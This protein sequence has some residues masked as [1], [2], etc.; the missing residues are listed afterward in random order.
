VV[1]IA[2]VEEFLPREMGAVIGDDR[3]EYA[4]AIDDVSEERDRLLRA[5]VDVGSSLDPLRELVH[6]YEKVGEAP[7][8]LSERDHY[9][10]VPNCEGPHDGDRLQYLRQEMSLPGVELAS[11]ATPYSVLRVGGRCGIVETL[12]ESF[13]DKRSRSGMVTACAGMYLSQQPTPLIPEDAPH[14]YAGSFMLVELAVNEDKSLCSAGDA[15]CLRLVG[16]KLPLG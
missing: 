10:E 12:S 9:V 15:L 3:V 13:P 8:R 6:H 11:F 16:R 5:D 4:E 1:V 14:E 7:G 2:E